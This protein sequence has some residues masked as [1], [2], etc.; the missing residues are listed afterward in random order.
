MGLTVCTVVE[1]EGWE[2]ALPALESFATQ[3]LQ[4]VA[5]AEKAGGGVAALFAADA[6]MKALNARWRGLDKPTN[7]LAFPAAENCENW[8][9][10]LALGL[11]TVQAEAQAQGKSFEA[12]L[13]HLLVHG[14]LHLLK[15]DHESE[16]EAEQMEARERALLAQLGYEDPYKGDF[17]PAN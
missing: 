8:L 1:A 9:G 15:Y 12:H 14:M 4:H 7:V 6:D 16:A 5:D 3:I 17:R 2:A 11:E 10:D 13:A